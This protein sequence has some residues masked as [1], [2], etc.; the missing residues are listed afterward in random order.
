M[1]SHY[2][3]ESK[4]LGDYLLKKITIEK[5]HQLLDARRSFPARELEFGAFS[6]VLLHPTDAMLYKLLGVWFSNW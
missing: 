3:Q 4:E 5:D 6:P 1:G 2:I